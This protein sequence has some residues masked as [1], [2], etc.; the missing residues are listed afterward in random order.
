VVVRVLAAFGNKVYF[1]PATDARPF[2]KIDSKGKRVAAAVLMKDLRARKLAV[3]PL[4][5]VRYAHD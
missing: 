3:S 1:Q 4:G 2:A 5:D